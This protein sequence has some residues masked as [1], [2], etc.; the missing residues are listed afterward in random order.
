MDRDPYDDHAL[1]AVLDNLEEMLAGE[2]LAGEAEEGRSEIRLAH[3]VVQYVESL[4]GVDPGLVDEGV[5][6][7][8]AQELRMLVEYLTA[9]HSGPRGECWGARVQRS[10]LLRQCA[11]HRDPVDSATASQM[12]RYAPPRRRRT[13]TSKQRTAEIAG[14]REQVGALKQ[15][16]AEADE[17]HR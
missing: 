15:R 8:L 4:R 11:K 16:L 9:C 3:A 14:L 6:A 13:G 17:P 10:Y 1:W 12:N 7:S 2:T 5:L